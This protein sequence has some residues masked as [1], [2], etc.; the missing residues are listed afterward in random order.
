MSKES[1]KPKPIDDVG[2][3]EVTYYIQY[4]TDMKQF[5]LTMES[6]KVPFTDTAEVLAALQTFISDCI[7]EEKDLFDDIELPAGNPYGG[8]H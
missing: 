5:S 3:A 2:A 1:S 6:D 4:T 7:D 8:V